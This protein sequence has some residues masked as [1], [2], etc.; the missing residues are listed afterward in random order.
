MNAIW[1]TIN[2]FGTSN[3]TVHSGSGNFRVTRLDTGTYM[4]DFADNSFKE[5]PALI[6]TQQYSDSTS[7][8]DF[9]SGGGST[10]DNSVIVALDSE[11]AK[12]KVGDSGGSV[13]DRNFSFIAIG[14]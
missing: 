3:P 9:S 5:T 12:I 7:W 10:L 1:G 6:L 14:N 2:A 4:I 13:Q 8:T 11:Q